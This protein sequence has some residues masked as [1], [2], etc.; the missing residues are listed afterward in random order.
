MGLSSVV[1]YGVTGR[2][3]LNNYVLQP[4]EIVF[5]L[6]NSEGP[7][8]MPRFVAFHLGLHCLS[9]FSFRG[10][11]N[12]KGFNINESCNYFTYAIVE[13]RK[14]RRTCANLCADSPEHSMLVY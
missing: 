4:R 5:F 14:L 13:H 6:A 8:E 10:F 11:Q 2:T 12:T 7:D 9:K 3:F 1:F